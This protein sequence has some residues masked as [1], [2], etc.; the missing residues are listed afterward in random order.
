MHRKTRARNAMPSFTETTIRLYRRLFGTPTPAGQLPDGVETVLDGN[1]AVAIT[2][3]CI[4]DSAGLGA[5]FPSDDTGLAWRSEQQRNGSNMF[6]GLLQSHEAEGARGALAAATGMSMAGQRAAV[7]LSSQDLAGA[8]DLLVSAAGRRL[9]LVVHLSNRALA[10]QGAALGSGHETVHLSADSGCFTLFAANAQQAVDFTLIA[11]RVAELGLTPGIVAM[12]S[13][14]TASAAQ[15]VKLP[16]GQLVNHFI[17]KA[18]ESI[19]TP[20]EA[21]KLL[22][23][24]NRRRVPQWHDLDRPALHGAL[25]DIDSYALGHAAQAHYFDLHLPTL[26]DEA[27]ADFAHLTGRHYSPVSSFQAEK[28]KLLLIAQG[29]AIETACAVAEHVHKEHKIKVGVIGLHGLRPFP[30]KALAGQ[31]KG[32]R[33]VVVLERLDTPLADDPPL[34]RELRGAVD[35]ALE[36]GRFTTDCHPGYPAIREGERPRLLSVIYGLGGLPLRAADLIEL[37]TQMNEKSAAQRYLGLDFHHKD[38]RHPK[39]QVML[40]V[41]RRHYPS[42]TTLGLRSSTT[43]PNLTPEGTTGITIHRLA[44]EGLDG[45]ALEAAS[46]LHQLLGGQVR[47]RGTMSWE[48]WGGIHRDRL[49]HAPAHLYDPGE[50]F[51]TDIALVA[52]DPAHPNLRPLEGVCQG[53]MLLLSGKEEDAEIWNGLSGDLHRSLKDK[54]ARLYVIPS[55]AEEPSRPRHERLLGGLFG[56]L[57]QSGRLA[58]KPRRV[59]SAREEALSHLTEAERAPLIKAFN[60]GLEGVHHLDYSALPAGENSLAANWDDEA[61]LT[62]RHLGR[63]GDSYD[64]LPRF[65]D[66]VGVLYRQG[67]ASALTADPYMATGSIPPLSASFRDLSPARLTLPRFSAENCTAC[68]KC[69]SACPDSAIGAV[70]ISPK[71][72]VET[73]IRLTESTEVRAIAGK[74]ATGIATLIRKGA[75]SADSADRLLAE[76]YAWLQEK[77]PVAEDRRESIESALVRMQQELAGLP[78]SVTEPLFAQAEKAQKDSGELLSLVINPDSCKACG[79]CSE[80]CADEAIEMVSQDDEQGCGAGTTESLVVDA[81]RNWRLWQ[82]TPDTSSSTIERLSKDSEMG[83]MAAVMLSRHCAFALTGGDGAEAGS[84][85][86]IAVRQVLAATEYQ[87]QPLLHR[88]IQELAEVRET[89]S[90]T[91]RDTL[92]EALPS[93]DLERLS[94][95]LKKIHT[96]EVSLSAFIQDGDTLIE[97]SGVDAPHLRKLIRMAQGLG[98]LHWRISQ[99]ANGLGRARY[100]IAVAPGSAAAWAGAFPHNPFHAPVTIDMTGDAAQVAA[101]LMQGQMSEALEAARLLRQARAELDP[102]A[103]KNQRKDQPLSWADLSE[104]ERLLCPPLLL[105]GNDQSLG[106]RGFAQLAWLL[107]S[108]LP[109]KIVVLSELDFGLGAHGITDAP[110]GALRDARNDLAMMALA[111]RRAYV[112]QSSFAAPTHMRDSVREAMRFS[113]P[114]LI[115]LHAP[116]PERHGFAPTQSLAMAELALSTRTTPLFR[117]HPEGEGVFGSRLSLE[118]NPETHATWLT[119]DSGQVLTP[120]H[121]ALRQQRFA[122]RL[123]PL[124]ADAPYPTE[125]DKWLEVEQD[126]RS[127]KTPFIA[128]KDSEGKEQRYAVEAAMAAMVEERGQM[129]RTLQ[130]LAGMVTPFTTRVEQEAR[131]SLAAAHQADLD[132]LKRDYEEKLRV[133]EEGMQGQMHERIT[134]RLMDLAGYNG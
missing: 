46:F 95:G 25:Q 109:V 4:A 3:A 80:L 17:G 99:G 84:G 122:P 82:Q 39:R 37:C 30:G 106:G 108:E 19:T 41:L 101:G 61:P 126:K 42:I 44:A 93:E 128:V 110:L 8:Q 129:W 29:A 118:G 70:A 47:S 71:G 68:G 31:L 20:G 97:G 21:Q 35:R 123:Q 49:L 57:L 36:N 107:N 81:R 77:S 9:P 76:A 58:L 114:A 78:V 16:S 7:F 92:A 72:L 33:A 12:D 86:K 56:A 15:E 79:L 26:L 34:L 1:T 105:I 65:W 60:E 127:G 104:E 115:C 6:G 91:I 62:V 96:R 133:L 83:P 22:F 120:A 89:I 11:R 48:R 116:S 55:K 102:K 121:W 51:P 23:G 10:S 100:G 98:E 50:E 103:A 69:W 63:S 85:E 88:F 130:E 90:K 40:D 73:G 94:Q 54:A 14:Q 112:A 117:Y 59:T 38:T 64:S 53:G 13:E 5:S 111:Q 75:N 113:G 134:R 18:S 124:A 28:A 67:E 2:E 66:Q 87:Q 32:K 45:L 52:T 132:A 27:F 119:H 125:L 74:L 24:E 131:E 43:S